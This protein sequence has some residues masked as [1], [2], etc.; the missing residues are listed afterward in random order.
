MSHQV[1]QLQGRVKVSRQLHAYCCGHS[2][3][4]NCCIGALIH[5]GAARQQHE[6][7]HH[8]GNSHCMTLPYVSQDAL[9][10]PPAVLTS[11][12]GRV[13]AACLHAHASTY[14]SNL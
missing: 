5:A 1:M 14:A 4:S 13:H 8:S 10:L 7:I 3:M 6:E 2:S 9:G 12:M 11:S